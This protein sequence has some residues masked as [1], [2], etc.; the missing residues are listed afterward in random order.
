MIVVLPM[1]YRVCCGETYSQ[2][3]MLMVG[4]HAVDCMM[5]EVITLAR[6]AL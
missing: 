2:K 3:M 1:A 6:S 5:S 4:D